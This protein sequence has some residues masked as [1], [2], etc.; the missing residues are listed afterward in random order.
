MIDLDDLVVRD[1]GGRIRLQADR[2]RLL[3]RPKASSPPNHACILESTFAGG[4]QL[5]PSS[6]GRVVS[7][8]T[9]EANL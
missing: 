3:V 5:S 1:A 4:H 9:F 8:D 2:L 6:C 7:P